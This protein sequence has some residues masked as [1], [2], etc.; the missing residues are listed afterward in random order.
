MQKLKAEI[1]IT[2]PADTVLVT[3]VEYDE[4][5]QKELSG[6]YWNMKELEERINKNSEWI[7][8]NILYPTRF[9]KTLDSDNGGFVFYPKS[10]GQ[11]WSFQ[12]TKILNT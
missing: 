12:A 7:K 1:V 2:I 3:K 11:T 9:K 8:E 4:L 6:V 5:K 10:K